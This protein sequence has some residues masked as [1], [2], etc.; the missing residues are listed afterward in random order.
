M[1]HLFESQFSKMGQTCVLNCL[2]IIKSAFLTAASDFISGLSVSG[3]VVKFP[4]AMR[5]PRIRFPA[6]A[7]LFCFLFQSTVGQSVPHFCL[8]FVCRHFF[9][10]KK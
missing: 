2:C 7:F 3:L 8:I 1:I 5:E 4:L 10:Q 6:D 9:V